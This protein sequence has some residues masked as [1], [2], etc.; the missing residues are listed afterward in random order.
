VKRTSPGFS[1]ALRL[2]LW[3]VGLMVALMTGMLSGYLV[4]SVGYVGSRV[5]ARLR[6]TGSAPPGLDPGDPA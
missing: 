4:I 2:T 3:L 1:A 5:V 6:G